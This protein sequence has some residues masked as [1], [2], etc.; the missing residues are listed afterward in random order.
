MIDI[1]KII[2]IVCLY[3]YILYI[4]L[5]R[6]KNY[7]REANWGCGAELRIQEPGGEG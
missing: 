3:V 5:C 7:R 4:Y 1:G 2:D 6:K